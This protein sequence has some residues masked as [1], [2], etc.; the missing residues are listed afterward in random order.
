MFWHL[1]EVTQDSI[2]GF[3]EEGVTEVVIHYDDLLTELDRVNPKLAHVVRATSEIAAAAVTDNAVLIE[4]IT[5]ECE[6]AI[7]IVLRLVSRALEAKAMEKTL[8]LER[9]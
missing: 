9:R 6:V 8:K 7:L 4:E 2:D 3:G 5:A 1:P